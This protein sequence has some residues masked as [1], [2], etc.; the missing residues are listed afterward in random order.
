M[1]TLH[2]TALTVAFILQDARFIAARRVARR[3]LRRRH[4]TLPRR[5]GRRLMPAASSGEL[6]AE[7]AA[8]KQANVGCLLRARDPPAPARR[9]SVW[10]TP[11]DRRRHVMRAGCGRLRRV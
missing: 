7:L 5:A 8:A 10:S 3:P 2:R 6:R 11:A 1:Y 9:A 4:R